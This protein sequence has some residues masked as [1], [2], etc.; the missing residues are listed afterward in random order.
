MLLSLVLAGKDEGEDQN[1]VMDIKNA[2]VW[3]VLD[4]IADI[5]HGFVYKE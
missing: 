4:V 2:L 1:E 5:V 3:F